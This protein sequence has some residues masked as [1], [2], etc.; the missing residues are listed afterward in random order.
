MN[1]CNKNL[2]T[3][4]DLIIL[5]ATG[6]LAHKKLFPALYNLYDD[7]SFKEKFNI[8]ALG[9]QN[10]SNSEFCSKFNDTINPSQ[11]RDLFYNK[12]QYI[13]CDFTKKEELKL[14]KNN[15]DKTCSSK[16]LYLALPPVIYKDV[17]QALIEAQF[18]IPC[19][20]HSTFTRIVLEK[21]FGNNL[22]SAIELNKTILSG[23]K[24]K[25][26]FRIDHY[27]GKEP[28]QNIF[29]F[30]FA[31]NSFENIW[32]SKYIDNIQIKV[33]E[34]IGVE[35]RGSFY[36]ANGALVDVFQNHILQMLSILT[37]D[38][39]KEFTEGYIREEKNNILKTLIYKS[40][41][42]GQYDGYRDEDNVD[43]NSKRETF[44]AVK[45]D[46]NSKRWENTPIYIQTG[47]YLN[48]KRTEIS[49]VFKENE[50]N[51]FKEKNNPN[52]LKFLIQPELGIELKLL[53]KVPSIS[54]Y[55]LSDID[56]VYRYSNFFRELKSEYEKLLIDCI[57]GNQIN[58]TRSDEI[59]NAWRLVDEIEDDIKEKEPLIYQKE[60]KGPSNTDTFIEQDS[61]YWQ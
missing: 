6:D 16:I 9:R 7:F 48:E 42:K 49:V 21:P 28:I 38:R 36:D 4:I 33:L 30:R 39:P 43:K 53:G 14:L 27:L 52:V 58:F 24:E 23:F 1:K 22:E 60:S 20:E 3:S 8:I 17:I 32:S 2:K 29:S 50:P 46:I 57:L 34:D 13:Q 56:M 26:V 11:K 15:L 41:L 25:Q 19:E 59:D 55:M 61:R 12:I 51:L 40:S 47:K 44:I 10:L 35:D 54:D 45:L 5:G 37:M 18:N 31:N